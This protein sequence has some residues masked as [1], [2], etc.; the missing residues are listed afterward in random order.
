MDGPFERITVDHLVQGQT[1][2]TW[3]LAR[4]FCDPDPWLLKLQ[5]GHTGV[6]DADDW[7][8]V[9][10][11]AP[12][13]GVL[14]DPEARDDLGTA[15]RTH[16]R[17]VLRTPRGEYTSRPVPTRAAPD[18][19]HWLRAQAIARKERLRLRRADAARGW[20]FKRKREGARPDPGKPRQT[21]TSFLTGEVVRGQD[22]RTLGTEFTGGY[23]APV[24]FRVDFRPA[25][26]HEERD[27]ARARGTVD[28]QALMQYGRVLLDPPLAE[29]DVFVAE[30]SDERFY[31]H[32]VKVN[33]LQGRIPLTA[34]VNLRL[35][36]RSDVIYTLPVPAV[37]PFPEE[38]Y[39]G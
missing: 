7:A 18:V 13:V 16:Y 10:D 24:P 22:R 25:G 31:I 39:C 8:D 19:E 21:V 6:P 3:T 15:W 4:P 17:V 30:G 11:F 32:D 14:V 5:W 29:G 1:R 20:L 2:V 12:D 28:D 26:T 9:A 38:A 36:P 23:Y 37:D 27:G 33:A 35:A 34:D